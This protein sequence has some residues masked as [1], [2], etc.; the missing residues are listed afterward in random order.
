MDAGL[1]YQSWPLMNGSFFPDDSNIKD[2][3]S[4]NSF[5]APSIV[6]FIHRNIAYFIFVF[7]LF[8]LIKVFKNNDFMYLRKTILLVFF[9]LLL[10]I[11]L[12]IITVLSGAQIF[13]ASMHQMGSIFLVSVSLILIFKNSKIN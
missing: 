9:V 10:Q 13:I 2:L 3:F 8:I 12:G 5:E 1:I 4:L 11:F 7:L 6:Q